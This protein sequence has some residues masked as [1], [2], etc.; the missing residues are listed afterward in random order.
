MTL[1]AR[2]TQVARHMGGVIPPRRRPTRNDVAAQLIR[3]FQHTTTGYR[4]VNLSWL[5]EVSVLD[6]R[7]LRR[8]PSPR[9]IVDHV[10]DLWPVGKKARLKK[11]NSRLGSE[12]VEQESTL[13]KLRRSRSSRLLSKVYRHVNRRMFMLSSD[14][15]FSAPRPAA[16]SPH[17]S[18]RGTHG[19]HGQ[20]ACSRA[21]EI[22]RTRA[23]G[24]GRGRARALTPQ[25]E[26]E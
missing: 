13:S 21:P 26:R 3:R 8:P 5:E 18:V 9:G 24:G 10:V 16:P 11:P 20:S 4:D 22:S 12:R 6:H 2:I 25:R 17:E 14:S 1:P 23:R 15:R 19:A 7:L